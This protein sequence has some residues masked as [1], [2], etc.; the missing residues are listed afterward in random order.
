MILTNDQAKQF[1]DLWIP[2]L[3]FVNRKYKLIRSL[4]GM[5]SPQGLPMDSVRLLSSKLWEKPAVIDEFLASGDKRMNQEEAELVGSWKRAVHGR[6][7]VD[8]HL[9][10][11]SVLISMEDDE[12]YIVKGIY[13]SWRE[14]LGDMPVPMIVK[15]TLIPFQDVIIHDSLI[16]PW[17]GSVTKEMADVSQKIY[18]RAR[19]NG[20]LHVSL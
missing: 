13:S 17:D 9:R 10:R 4:Y 5:T 2:L 16:S 8:R 6:F 14:M 3:D 7:V 20:T 18:F 15:A 1:Y 19:E 11:G 12:V